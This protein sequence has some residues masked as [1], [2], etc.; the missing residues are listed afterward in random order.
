MFDLK[1][2]EMVRRVMA[3]TEAPQLEVLNEHE[4]YLARNKRTARNTKKLSTGHDRFINAPT[5]EQDLHQYLHDTY[6]AYFGLFVRAGK[7]QH[8]NH[9][10]N[11]SY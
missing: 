6:P 7:A 5:C 11:E 10:M 8:H 4:S 1:F 9:A 3:W 2:F